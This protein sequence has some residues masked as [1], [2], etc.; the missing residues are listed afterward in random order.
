MPLEAVATHVPVRGTH[1]TPVTVTVAVTVAPNPSTM[2]EKEM[3]VVVG[4]RPDLPHRNQR[5]YARCK[6]TAV[7]Q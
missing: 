5:N 2:S 6:G 1:L 7:V 3:E 4:P